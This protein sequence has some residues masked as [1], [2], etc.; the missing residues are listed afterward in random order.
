MDKLGA[1][2]QAIFDTIS[3]Y[4]KFPIDGHHLSVEI[5]NRRICLQ[6]TYQAISETEFDVFA[7]FFEDSFTLYC[8]G[9]HEEFIMKKSP[10]ECVTNILEKLKSI[11]EGKVKIRVTYAGKFP[12]KWEILF[13]EGINWEV[14]PLMGLFFYNYFGKRKTIEKINRIII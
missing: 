13:Y 8:D 7:E 9:C 1:K 6:F 11:F 12:Y 3:K 5:K 10:T 2:Q 14:L 4:S